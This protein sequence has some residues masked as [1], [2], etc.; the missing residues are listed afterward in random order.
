MTGNPGQAIGSNATDSGTKLI[1]SMDFPNA[2][3]KLP[4]PDVSPR[5]NL[6]NF[7]R[8]SSKRCIKQTTQWQ[9]LPVNSSYQ[10]KDPGTI[11]TKP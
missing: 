7:L 4:G 1:S 6:T 8:G 2:D 3:L 5:T 11:N 10:A 9:L